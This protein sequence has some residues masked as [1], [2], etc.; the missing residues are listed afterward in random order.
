MVH[1]LELIHWQQHCEP[2]FFWSL[3]CLSCLAY[4]R[5]MGRIQNETGTYLCDGESLLFHH[6]MQY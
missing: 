6:L 1:S 5:L 2:L 4:A 3:F